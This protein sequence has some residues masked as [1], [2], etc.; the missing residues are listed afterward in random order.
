MILLEK[1][2]WLFPINLNVTRLYLPPHR[3]PPIGL[4][5]P[6]Q[7]Q[8]NEASIAFF[9]LGTVPAADRHYVGTPAAD[10]TICLCFTLT[11][12]DFNSTF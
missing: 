7:G 11:R 4:I 6:G 9:L 2:I 3:P 8:I 1:I 5:T 10:Q 12:N